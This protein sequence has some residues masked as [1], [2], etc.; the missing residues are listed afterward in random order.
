MAMPNDHTR[1]MPIETQPQPESKP[2]SAA[3]AEDLEIEGPPSLIQEFKWFLQENKKWW[4]LPLIL[5]FLA[6]AGLLYFGGTSLA[7]FIYTL[8]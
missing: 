7:P 1:V 3:P 5:V 2:A 6:M 4:L 8:F